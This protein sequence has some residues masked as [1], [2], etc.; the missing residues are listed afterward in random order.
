MKSGIE[1]LFTFTLI[2]GYLG[3]GAEVKKGS[4][5]LL[6]ETLLIGTLLNVG[7]FHIYSKF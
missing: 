5:R 1:L 4:V 3:C 2:L 7:K 6:W